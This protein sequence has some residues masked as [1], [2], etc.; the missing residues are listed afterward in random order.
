MTKHPTSSLNLIYSP[1]L[2]TIKFN[3]RR[4]RQAASAIHDQ[5]E[6]HKL[7]EYHDLHENL[8]KP[9]YVREYE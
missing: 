2:A 5:R 3:C 7:R 9:A 8:N 4:S 1:F 6:K